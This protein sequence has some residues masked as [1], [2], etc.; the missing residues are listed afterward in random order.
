VYTRMHTRAFRVLI[1]FIIRIKFSVYGYSSNFIEYIQLYT[2]CIR[3]LV[4]LEESA[5]CEWL[6]IVG[7]G[8][9]RTWC[10]ADIRGELD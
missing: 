3:I 4:V 7:G 6:K 2:F 5:F 1:F 10:S 8:A 9:Q